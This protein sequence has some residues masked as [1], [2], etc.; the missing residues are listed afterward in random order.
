MLEKYG[1]TQLKKQ[2]PKKSLRALHAANLAKKA[3]I[4]Y[5]VDSVDVTFIK[6]VQD[7]FLSW[8]I[9]PYFLGYIPSKRK[10]NLESNLKNQFFYK[11]DTNLF[12]IPKA[13]RIANFCG[14]NFDFL[15]NL[16]LEGI[17]AL[18]GVSAFSKA[19][20]RFGKYFEPYYFAHDCMV[21]YSDKDPK[22]LFDQ[23]T[24]YIK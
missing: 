6:Y 10:E 4:V 5:H 12:G 9:E 15:I 3:G 22:I 11:S 13:E 16:D 17:N 2:A 24:N 19:N 18:Q 20:T 7:F 23:I 21:A 14:E 1:I 8:G